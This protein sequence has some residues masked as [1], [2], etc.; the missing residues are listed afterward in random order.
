[1]GG[2]TDMLLFSVRRGSAIIGTPD[3][4]FGL[5]I[6][7]GD[8]LT[9]PLAGSGNPFPGIYIAAENLGLGTSR[10]TPGVVNDDLDAL[11]IGVAPI[12]DC[13][14][15]GVEDAV[16]IAL[17]NSTD[18]NTNGVPDECEL[19]TT[20]YCFCAPPSPAPCG[21]FYPA[22]GCM[23]STGVGAILTAAGTTS[24]ANDN[25]V[26]NT[27][28]MPINRPGLMAMS[29]SPIAPVPFWDGLRCFSGPAFRLPFQNTGPLGAWTYGPGLSAYSIGNFPPAGWILPG[30]TMV[31]QSWFRDPFGPCGTLA[32]TSNAIQAQFTP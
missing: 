5:P 24:V 25:L 29:P 27:V 17:G 8:I 18:V 16:D 23:N 4:I 20:A 3:S 19:L 13:N 11:D 12:K 22:G 26:L 6:S 1:M 28:Q 30:S 14:G 21:N 9:T 7:E 10:T 32:N 15:N 2:A 31:F